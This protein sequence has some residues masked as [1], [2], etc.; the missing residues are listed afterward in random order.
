V[1]AALKR[2]PRLAGLVYG[3]VTSR[4]FGASLGINLTPGAKVCTFDCRYCQLGWTRRRAARMSEW[5]R[6]DDVARALKE[7]LLRLRDRGTLLDAIT[8]SG[9]GEPTSHPCFSEAVWATRLVR[10]EVFPQARI[11]ALTNGAHLR[12]ADVV[13]GLNLCDERIV[14]LDAGN[15]SMFRKLNRPAHG[16]T[17]ES[18]L[19]GTGRLRSP[20]IQ[21]MFVT[22]AIDNSTEEQV[23]SWIETVVRVA[24]ASGQIYTLDRLPADAE[25]RPV[26]RM[27][28]M[29]IALQAGAAWPVEFLTVFPD[30][31]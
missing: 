28:L 30:E 13:A 19:E 20:V 10:N 5:P 8:F 21:S 26:S 25:V 4:R 12:R 22:G 9:N 31:P 29:E 17:L 18:I 23:A 14:K 15:E 16:V 6:A 7:R 11:V 2:F 3:P 1:T 27:R 24:P